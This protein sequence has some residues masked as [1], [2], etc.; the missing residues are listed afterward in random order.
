MPSTRKARLA[1]QAA[2]EQAEQQQG[3]D[4]MVGAMYAQAAAADRSAGAQEELAN[5]EKLK[6]QAALIAAR[7]KE[8]K[9]RS[10]YPEQYAVWDA[11]GVPERHQIADEQAQP[12]R[13]GN[14]LNAARS[15]AAWVRGFRRR[16]QDNRPT[17]IDPDHKPR[18][19][20]FIDPVGK[21]NPGPAE[22]AKALPAPEGRTSVVR[23]VGDGDN[24][25]WIFVTFL[26]QHIWTLIDGRYDISPTQGGFYIGQFNSG[27]AFPSRQAA[28]VVIR[29]LGLTAQ[30]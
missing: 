26:P 11:E 30:Q 16:R 4:P 10:K 19:P 5:A 27:A 2:A 21:L 8:A 3:G 6:A 15:A 28:V 22:G 9:A 25:F 1:A 17:E 7:A 24:G 18:R 29:E 23:L 20:I 13:L 14:A 12:D